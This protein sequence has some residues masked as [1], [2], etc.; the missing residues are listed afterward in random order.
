M[1][2]FTIIALALVSMSL[3]G[4]YS[5]ATPEAV[6]Q[7]AFKALLKNDVKKFPKLLTGEAKAQYGTLKGMGDLQARLAPHGQL[8]LGDVTLESTEEFGDNVGAR[9]EYSVVVLAAD[10]P[11]FYPLLTATVSCDVSYRWP[12][13]GGPEEEPVQELVTCRIA[14]LSQR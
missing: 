6:L 5:T 4:C 7:S 2:K 3:S 11:A 1:N 9:R 12:H 10:G 13:T 14:A 8:T